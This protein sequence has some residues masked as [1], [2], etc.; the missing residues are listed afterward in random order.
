MFFSWYLFYWPTYLPSVMVFISWIVMFLSGNFSFSTRR[1]VFNFLSAG[2]L[3]TNFLGH[4]LLRKVFISFSLL[5]DIF[6]GQIF[7]DA[8][9]SFYHFIYVFHC[10]LAFNVSVESPIYHIVG[11]LKVMCLFFWLFKTFFLRLPTGLP[12]MHGCGFLW[13]RG[14]LNSWIWGLIYLNSSENS[15]PLSLQ[16]LF[17][18]YYLFCFLLRFH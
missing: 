9:T 13:F 7:L 3:V 12:Y 18:P 14:L 11:P 1:T 16:I 6:T 4:C 17:L 15:Q 5:K 8:F 10:F 2:L